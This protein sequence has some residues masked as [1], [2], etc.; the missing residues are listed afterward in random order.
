MF[1]RILLA[2]CIFLSTHGLGGT[3]TIAYT[4]NRQGETKTCGCKIR[5]IGGLA[6]MEERLT[7]LKKSGGRLFLDAGNSFFPAPKIALNREAVEKKQALAIASS[8]R[9]ME[10]DVFSP[11]ERDFAG[12]SAFLGELI[13]KSGAEV[14]SANLEADPKDIAF[15]PF[16]IRIL[17]DMRIAVTGLT[18][19]SDVPAP[20]E[21]KQRDPKEAFE[22]VWK[23]IQAEKPDRFIILSH[24]GTKE[25]EEL[26]KNHPGVWI[27]GSKSMDFFDRPKKTGDSFLFEVG[28]GGQRLGEISFEKGRSGWSQAKLTELGEEFDRPNKKRKSSVK[29]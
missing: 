22:A 8:Y 15:R 13:R 16:V 24:L 18:A 20:Q 12:G 9:L 14:V 11:G 6:R 7:E 19:F 29:K 27:I 28:I 25:D 5:D 2:A 17:G 23:K 10:L 1:H 21:I 26:A 3:G 4:A